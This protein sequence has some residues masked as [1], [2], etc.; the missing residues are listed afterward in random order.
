M[1]TN[2]RTTNVSSIAP[3]ISIELQKFI[4]KNKNKNSYIETDDTGNAK[5]ILKL[6]EKLIPDFKKDL[7]IVCKK[8]SIQIVKE[9]K[10]NLIPKNRIKDLTSILVTKIN[11]DNQLVVDEEVVILLVKILTSFFYDVEK[12]YKIKSFDDLMDRYDSHSNEF[13]TPMF[14]HSISLHSSKIEKT[15]FLAKRSVVSSTTVFCYKNE[16]KGLFPEE[17]KNFTFPLQ[18]VKSL[19]FK[20]PTTDFPLCCYFLILFNVPWMFTNLSDIHLDLDFKLKNT[21][22]RRGSKF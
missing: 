2:T 12:E 8:L 16:H 14:R 1:K 7:L 13:S 3:N 6:L 10:S 18:N 9:S 5:Q 4:Y 15:S 22:S 19:K 17:L 11:S 20:I 21:I